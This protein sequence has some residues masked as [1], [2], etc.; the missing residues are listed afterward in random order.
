MAISGLA[1]GKPD[2]YANCAGGLRLSEPA[3][4]RALV[5]AIAS[6]QLGAPLPYSMAA[7]PRGEVGLTGE[8][9]SV[10]NWNRVSKNQP[11]MS[12]EKVLV[13]APSVPR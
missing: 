13:P 12:F 2:V 10:T 11:K 3:P 6:S 9:R 7:P 5:L 1:P 8:V 4:D